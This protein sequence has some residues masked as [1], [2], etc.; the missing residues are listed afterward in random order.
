VTDTVVV[1]VA[2]VVTVAAVA[3]P[4]LRLPADVS[5]RRVFPRLAAVVAVA[6]VAW[7]VVVA[8]VATLAPAVMVPAAVVAVVLWAVATWRA[9]RLTGGNHG[10]PPGSVSVTGSIQALAH[11]DAYQRDHRRYGPVFTSSQFGRPVVCVVGLERGQRL[12][13]GHR[14]QLGP[15]PLPFTDQVM[16]GFLRYMDDDT[17]DLYG[18]AFRQAMSRAV[19]EAAL[20][21]TRQAV[22]HELS[23]LPSTPVHPAAAM[24]RIATDTLMEALFGIDATTAEGVAFAAAHQRFARR[25]LLG[26]HRRT[27]SALVELRGLVAAQRHR[28]EVGDVEAVCALGEFM[29][30]NNDLPDEICIDNL[31]FMLRIGAPNLQGLLVW[32]MQLLAENPGWLDRLGRTDG[33]TNEGADGGAA[34]DAVD[35]FVLE[36]LR[37]AQSEYLYR[38][39]TS[40]VDFDGMRLRRGQLVRLCVWES[41][42][43]PTVFADP[44]Q[45]TDRFAHQRHPQSE[46]CPFGLDGHACNAVGLV[47][48]AARTVVHEVAADPGVGLVPAA[49]L[50]RGLRHWSH[51][52]PGDDLSWVRHT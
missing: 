19:T 41:H 32:L 18:P 7:T 51:W 48:M 39:V 52:R 4:W 3:V 46:Y 14:Q 42:Q 45:F 35:A 23:T 40:D 20:P 2:A 11:R 27:T 47:M 13:R 38:R 5:F 22:A 31:L 8:V 37:M 36:S 10:R 29:D 24:G 15:S 34:G 25:T 17:H 16:G 30:A 1:V 50:T 43:D 28:L 49:G 12:L 33:G 21:T 26:G 6:V 9:R 44:G